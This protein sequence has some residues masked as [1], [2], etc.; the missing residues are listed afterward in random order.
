LECAIALCS[1]DYSSFNE[2]IQTFDP[3]LPF[4][5]VYEGADAWEGDAWEQS[6]AQP[7]HVTY[8]D[9]WEFVH[10]WEGV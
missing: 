5:M 7:Y 2:L 8:Q 3:S 4:T 10:E 9:F 6:V 1:G